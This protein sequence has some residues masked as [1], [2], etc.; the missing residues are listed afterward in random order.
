MYSDLRPETLD[1]LSQKSEISQK[2]GI[3]QKTGFHLISYNTQ[4]QQ[5]SP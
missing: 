4:V 5:L 1:K 2:S 3:G